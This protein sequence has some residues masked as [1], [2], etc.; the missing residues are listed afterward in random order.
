MLGNALIGA[1]AATPNAL[2]QP[3]STADR[4][5]QMLTIAAMQKKGIN[6]QAMVAIIKKNE[7]PDSPAPWISIMESLM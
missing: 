2:P 3:T 6:P 5:A 4:K 7:Q 1:Q